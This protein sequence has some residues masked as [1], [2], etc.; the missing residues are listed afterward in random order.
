[1]RYSSILKLSLFLTGTI[2][3]LGIHGPVAAKTHP[4][5]SGSQSSVKKCEPTRSDYLG[6]Y[7]EP[8]APLRSSVGKGYR[9]Q[10]AVVSSANC[11]PIQNAQI[12]LWL[13]NPAGSYDDD[14]RATTFSDHT[15]TY[16]FESNFPPGYYGRPP[17]IHIRN[18]NVDQKCRRMGIA[19]E[20]VEAVLDYADKETPAEMVTLVVDDTNQAAI[21]LYKDLGFD[22]ESIGNPTTAMPKYGQWTNGRSM[23]FKKL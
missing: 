3:L 13:T 14:H 15:G 18:L 6:P 16:S 8:D 20:L 2:F 22:I 1:M 12:E 21:G 4:P 5:M 7:Y 9:L 17:H 10:G 23:M 11:N 19:R